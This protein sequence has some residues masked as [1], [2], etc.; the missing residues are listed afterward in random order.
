MGNTR[1]EI[2]LKRV[3][4][5]RELLSNTVCKYHM[6][7]YCETRQHRLIVSEIIEAV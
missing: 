7:S 6:F 3:Q 5:G 4:N 2:K 1:K